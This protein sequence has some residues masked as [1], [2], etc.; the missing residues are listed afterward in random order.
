MIK[1]VLFARVEEIDRS[2]TFYVDT[3]SFVIAD[4]TARRRA[5]ELGIDLNRI[6]NTAMATIEVLKPGS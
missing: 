3:G 5:K 1:V 4:K 2:H 6:C